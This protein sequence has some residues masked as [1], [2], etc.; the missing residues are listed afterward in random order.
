MNRYSF[1]G[2]VKLLY[3]K[4]D[5]TF[6]TLYGLQY[7]I[8]GSKVL[9]N[10]AT[11]D[12][13]KSYYNLDPGQGQS[14]QALTT[15]P[16]SFTMFY[17]LISDNVPLCG[18][19]RKSYLFISALLQ[20]L[21]MLVLGL[22]H[23]ETEDLAVWM[24]FLSHLSVAFSDVIVDSLMVIQ[25]RKYPGS[26]SEELGSYSWTCMALG[27]FCGSIAAAFLSENY[28]PQSCFFFSAAMGL[29]LVIVVSR[30]N[31]ALEDDAEDSQQRNRGS[32]LEN[33]KRN[34]REIREAFKIKQFQNMILYLII[35]GFLV[36][37]FF[38]FGYFF[39]LDVVKMSKFAYSMLAV[40]S[41]I[42]LYAG[43][44]VYNRFFIG[45]EFKNLI[46]LDA[47]IQLLLAPLNYLLI[48]R[49]NLEWGIPD[50][51]LVIFTESVTRSFS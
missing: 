11:S 9:V 39:M 36:P 13:F 37:N 46:V 28:E 33:V 42:F 22:Q 1:T 7:F 8:W 51:A 6:I 12:L 23:S 10:L 24:L 21:T 29:V 2:S 49:V 45:K 19:R 15:L 26:G 14:I 25:A 41:F 18:S 5:T 34:F 43:T 48:L 4:Y 16:W 32:F 17:G 20:F 40:L 44:Q 3:A 35:S 30:L 38:Q 27:G 47:L 50:L 31:V